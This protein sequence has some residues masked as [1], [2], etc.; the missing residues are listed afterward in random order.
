MNLV[1]NF[2]HDQGIRHPGDLGQQIRRNINTRYI[3]LNNSSRRPI[4]VAINNYMCPMDGQGPAQIQFILQGG[5]T[6]HLGINP[7]GSPAQFITLLD[8]STKQV[9]GGPDILE[10]PANSFVLRDGLNKWMV[11]KFYQATYR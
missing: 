2:N 3:S 9:V 8:P 5:E 11:Q 1:R 7:V 10:T 4:G 6:K